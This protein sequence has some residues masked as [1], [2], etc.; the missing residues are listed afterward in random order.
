MKNSKIVLVASFLVMAMIT[1]VFCTGVFADDNIVQN[2]GFEEPIYSGDVPAD[3][4]L[5]TWTPKAY[6]WA[7]IERSTEEKHSGSYSLKISNGSFWWASGYQMHYTIVKKETITCSV[8]VK[9]APGG[10]ERYFRFGVFDQYGN[11]MPQM[12]GAPI[13]GLCNDTG[14]TQISGTFR[15]A[16]TMENAFIGIYYQPGD[17]TPEQL[18]WDGA[19]YFDDVS[20]T[21]STGSTLA[22]TST[23][24]SEASS[25]V[26]SGTSSTAQSSAASSSSPSSASGSAGVSAASS[27]NETSDTSSDVSVDETSSDTED[28]E[29]ASDASAADSDTSQ[30]E[31][32]AA[33]SDAQDSEAPAD[34][35]GNNTVIAVIIAAAVILAAGAALFVIKRAK[36]K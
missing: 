15:P 7:T 14:W 3:D 36:K 17:N 28:S 9:V 1:A 11:D 5:L 12:I 29:A 16:V 23:P 27:Q 4:T 19:F 26:A 20:I 24:S 18:N 21:G 34:E 32:P 13:E 22:G 6:E 25:A 33:S 8:W 30:D 10:G 35:P 2:P 31:S